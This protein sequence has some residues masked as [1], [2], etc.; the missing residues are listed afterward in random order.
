MSNIRKK[1][2][3]LGTRRVPLWVDLW[4]EWVVIQS[5][6]GKERADLLDKCTEVVKNPKTGKREGKVNLER[7]YPMMTVLTVRNP[8]TSVLPDA[9]DPHYHLYPGAKDEQGNYLTEPLPEDE[10]GQMC[11]VLTDMAVLNRQDGAPLEQITQFSSKLSKLSKEDVDEEKN[12]SEQQENE[13]GTRLNGQTV[14]SDGY[15]IE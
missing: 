5:L 11:F 1:A 15:T 7:M 4:E 10:Q 14:E 6:T 9:K 2:L 13:D 12:V 3:E 8:V